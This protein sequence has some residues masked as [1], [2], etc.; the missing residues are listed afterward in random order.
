[1]SGPGAGPAVA[2]EDAYRWLALAP[3]EL[4]AQCRQSRFQ[5][6]GPGGQKRNRVYSAVRLAHPPSGLAA[7]GSERREAARNLQDAL[8]RLRLALSLAPPWEAGVPSPSEAGAR[9]VF[10]ADANPGH[11]DFPRSL[12]R[13]LH[14]LAFHGGR[15][16]EAAAALG[17][18]GS[19]LTRLLKEDKGA[20]VRTQAIRRRAGLAPLK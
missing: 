9:A 16:A 20:W 15:V 4:L 11:A 7:E 14:A 19:A 10:R 8:H 17:C 2:W 5:A 6:S 13:A 1:M 3:E 12:L 18:T